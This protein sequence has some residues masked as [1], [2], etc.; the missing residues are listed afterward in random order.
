M[1]A[2]R[3]T[4]AII[5]ASLGGSDLLAKTQYRY[6]KDN[7]SFVSNLISAMVMADWNGVLTQCTLDSWKEGLVAALNHNPTNAS[8]LCERLGERLQFE[9]NGD[10]ELLK[11]SI[12]CYICAG[13]IERIINAWTAVNGVDSLENSENL[14]DL[15]EIVVLLGRAMELKG[16]KVAAYGKYAELLSKYATLLASQGSLDTA[17]TYIGNSQDDANIIDLRERLYYALGHK[18]QQ[19][20]AQQNIFQKVNYNPQPRLSQAR[21]LSTSSNAGM[22]PMQPTLFQ[23]APVVSQPPMMFNTGLPGAPTSHFD[24]QWQQQQQQPISQPPPLVSQAP[25]PSFMNPTDNLPPPPRPASVSSVGSGTQTAAAAAK[26]KRPLDPSVQSGPTYGQLPPTAAPFSPQ[27]PS[28]FSTN[29]IQSNPYNTN[30]MMSSM[31]FAQ[32]AP[33]QPQSMWPNQ[34]QDYD[35]QNGNSGAGNMM[36][37]SSFQQPPPPPAGLNPTPPPGWNDPPEFKARSQ[38]RKNFMFTIES[39]AQLS[40]S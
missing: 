28:G 6:L 37:G 3:T 4:D 34:N 31:P 21:T 23:P 26:P 10:D 8:M 39:I 30:P 15:V 24:N 12:L 27:Q 20:T 33:M 35:Y 2:G 9:S 29:P 5:L 40:S 18:Q 38:V 7:E 19:Q 32:A 14:Q 22:P 36:N 11:N 1:N 25:P 17:L 16:N 13:N